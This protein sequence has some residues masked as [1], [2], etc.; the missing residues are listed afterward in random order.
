[1]GNDPASRSFGKRAAPARAA[2][3]AP[4]TAEPDLPGSIRG[5]DDGDPELDAWKRTRR[6]RLPWRQISF[7]ASLCFGVAA[8]VLPD[9]VN[10]AVSWMLYV[11]AAIGF[12]GGFR[13][14]HHR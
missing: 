8:L 3:A 13:G 6:R 7:T 2:Q 5:N 11:L 4:R 10:D 12:I 9:T 1:M 14:R